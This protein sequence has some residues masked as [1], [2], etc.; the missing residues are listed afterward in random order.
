MRRVAVIDLGTNTFHLLI[1]EQGDGH[2]KELER[3]RIYVKLALDGIEELSGAAMNRGM[4]ALRSLMDIVGRYQIDM[5]R[6]IGTAAL[7]TAKNAASYLAR[8]EDEIGIKVEI[9]D[10][11]EEARL[12]HLGVSLIWNKPDSP[13]LLMDIGGG[14]VEFI[15][16]DQHQFLWSAS[17]PLG[18]AVLYRKFHTE[19]PISKDSAAR[20]EHFVDEMVSELAIFLNKYQVKTLVGAS[21]TFDVIGDLAGEGSQDRYF[22]VDVADVHSIIQEISLMSFE[23]RSND[24]R[25]PASRVDM[26]VVALLLLQKILSLSPF[27]KIGISAYALKEGVAAEII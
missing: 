20:L 7:R 13:V 3:T 21:G 27:E 22:E 18:V 10:G 26:I 24:Q 2:F 1:V 16:A 14:S 9:I 25:I 17:Y 5:I 19:D 4:E 23:A 12:I 6:A 15:I 8:I 11:K